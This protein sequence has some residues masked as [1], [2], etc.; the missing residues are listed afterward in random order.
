M[1]RPDPQILIQALRTLIDLSK[2]DRG[3]SIEESLAAL[4]DAPIYWIE[5]VLDGWKRFADRYD[6]AFA[7]EIPRSGKVRCLRINIMPPI[8]FEPGERT[9]RLCGFQCQPPARSWHKECYLAFEPES[10][11]GWK[12]ITKEALK[13]CKQHCEACG[14]DLKI[15]KQTTLTPWRKV[16]DVDHKIALFK[17]GKHSSDNV[18]IL[19]Q[20][21]H[22]AKTKKDLQEAQ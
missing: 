22:K 16:Y 10:A 8:Q 13:R 1:D 21:C 12:R 20:D 4:P 18:Q 19:C 14:A 15:L 11:E 9:C 7:S 3:P 5:A 17:G 6:R 2:D